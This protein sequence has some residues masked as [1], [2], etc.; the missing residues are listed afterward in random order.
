MNYEAVRLC[1]QLWG[2]L[3]QCVIRQYSWHQFWAM[4]DILLT[5][6]QTLRVDFTQT[7]IIYNSLVTMARSI[8]EGAGMSLEFLSLDAIDRQ[9]ARA[10]R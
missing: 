10:T 2:L 4:Y 8:Y 3:H 5:T 6:L 7:M 1:S 9:A